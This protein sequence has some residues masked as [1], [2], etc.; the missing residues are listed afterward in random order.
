MLRQRV[1]EE[2]SQ[3]QISAAI[4]LANEWLEQHYPLRAAHV[5]SLLR[6]SRGGKGRIDIQTTSRN[7]PVVTICCVQE[8]DGL[9]FISAKGMIVRLQA[10]SISQIGRNTQGVRLVN[11]KS[12]DRFIAAAPMVETGLDET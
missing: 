9:M 3:E 7:G 11:L 1:A 12:G 5:I 10:A 6:Q 2:M 4:Q 8:S